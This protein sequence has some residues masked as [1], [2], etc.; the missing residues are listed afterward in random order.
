MSGCPEAE[1]PP[2]FATEAQAVD[3]SP[4]SSDQRSDPAERPSEKWRATDIGRFRKQCRL[5]GWDDITLTLHEDD[6]TADETAVPAPR[7]SIR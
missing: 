5:E 7:S 1:L 4:P 3:R 2:L 6:I